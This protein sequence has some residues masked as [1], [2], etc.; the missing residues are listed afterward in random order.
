MGWEGGIWRSI[1]QSTHGVPKRLAPDAIDTS[2]VA[3]YNG[4]QCDASTVELMAC[5]TENWRMPE[6]DSGEY[7][8]LD[9]E[10]WPNETA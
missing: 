3:P 9:Y 8:E 4:L 10:E 6:Q 5:L 1:G 7:V 2:F